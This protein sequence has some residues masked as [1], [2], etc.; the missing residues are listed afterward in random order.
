MFR[1]LEY[2]RLIIINIILLALWTLVCFLACIII[3]ESYFNPDKPM[4]KMKKWEK[5]GKWYVKNL[6]I[7]AW[8]D[9]LPQHIGRNGF[10]K[11]HFTD[12]SIDYI[13]KFIMETC[14]GEWDHSMNCL[15]AIIAI[16]INPFWI[17]I[18]F[19]FITLLINLPFIAIQRY[20]RFRL[21]T[22]RKRVSRLNQNN[23]VLKTRIEEA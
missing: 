4:Y 23:D 18:L 6:K 9:I 19:A 21:L 5:S 2:E 10:S 17:G 7:K 14:R 16:L 20:N 3:K 22:V 12:S 1:D 13:D 11:E 15:Y 8:K